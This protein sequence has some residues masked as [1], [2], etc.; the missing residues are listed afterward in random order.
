MLSLV[1]FTHSPPHP[2]PPSFGVSFWDL[3]GEWSSSANTLIFF[4]IGFLHGLKQSSV[5]RRLRTQSQSAGG[6]ASGKMLSISCQ[7]W[8]A[9]PPS[10][11]TGKQGIVLS[12]VWLRDHTGAFVPS[13]LESFCSHA[14]GKVQAF[15][16]AA[17]SENGLSS[18]QGHDNCKWMNLGEHRETTE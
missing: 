9:G 12:R 13:S 6:P 10:H 5:I 4:S 18:G 16:S 11:R 8:P 17:H 1:A 3:W 14:S 2:L 7:Q 15:T